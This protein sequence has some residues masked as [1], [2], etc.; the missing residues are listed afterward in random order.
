MPSERHLSFVL[1]P[2]SISAAA[3]TSHGPR[4]TADSKSAGSRANPRDGWEERAVENGR[5]PHRVRV[6]GIPVIR[7]LCERSRSVNAA[8]TCIALSLGSGHA[9]RHDSGIDSPA[10]VSERERI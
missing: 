2:F 7:W 6:A 10:A 4:D 5:S 8:S 1:N 3:F 9:S